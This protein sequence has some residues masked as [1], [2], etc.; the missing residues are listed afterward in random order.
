[1]WC[2][3]LFSNGVEPNLVASSGDTIDIELIT[4]HAG[5]DFDKMIQGDPGVE[6]IYKVCTLG[7]MAMKITLFICTEPVRNR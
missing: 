2:I 1:L 6:D 4:H 5:D 7:R 3:V